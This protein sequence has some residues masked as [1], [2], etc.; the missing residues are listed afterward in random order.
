[1]NEKKRPLPHPDET[2]VTPVLG[3][4]TDVWEQVNK[5][6][7]YE[8]QRTCGTENDFPQIAQGLAAQQAAQ[9]AEKAR[10]WRRRK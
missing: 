9:L 5:Y 1:M 10:R 7:T 4:P 8:V 6:G 3:E 2:A